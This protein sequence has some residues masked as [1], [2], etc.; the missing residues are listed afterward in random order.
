MNVIYRSCDVS[1]EHLAAAQQNQQ[2][3][4][5][6]H[7]PELR[8]RPSFV[9]KGLQD[10]FTVQHSTVDYKAAGAMERCRKQQTMLLR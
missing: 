6:Q 2:Q 5:E 4:V 9:C 10:C 7:P 3:Q 1:V 8:K